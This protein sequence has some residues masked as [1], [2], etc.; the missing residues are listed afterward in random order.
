MDMLITAS[1][2][3]V[4][5]DYFNLRSDVG[6]LRLQVAAIDTVEAAE[7]FSSEDETK[8]LKFCGIVAE[9]YTRLVSIMP[10][11]NGIRITLRRK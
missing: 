8:L 1:G 4:Q 2:K 6:R 5:C 3:N 11:L 7:I 9:G 10:V